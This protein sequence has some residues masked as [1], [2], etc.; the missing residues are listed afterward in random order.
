MEIID[1][2]LLYALALGLP[3]WLV[4]RW[5]YGQWRKA[6][7]P[8]LW[9]WVLQNRRRDRT[10]R[11]TRERADALEQRVDA[12]EL[13]LESYRER[14]GRAQEEGGDWAAQLDDALNRLG[15][16]ERALAQ[17]KHRLRQRGIG[18]DG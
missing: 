5:V 12:L 10:I 16:C 8:A 6:N 2:Y 9:A 1:P 14:S 4:L 11:A 17:L 18:I 15:D 13:L 7:A 3:A